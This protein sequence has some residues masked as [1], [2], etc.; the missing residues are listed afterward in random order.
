MRGGWW[1]LVAVCGPARDGRGD[2]EGG[3]QDVPR[4]RGKRRWLE[5]GRSPAPFA[6]P[7]RMLTAC[8]I[9]V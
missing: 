5:P 7:P 8:V 3:L 4:R 2:V 1:W 6:L 9:R